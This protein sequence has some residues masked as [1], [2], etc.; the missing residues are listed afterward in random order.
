M[1]GPVASQNAATHASGITSSFCV[2]SS[3]SSAWP[4]CPKLS[5]AAA[6]GGGR[7]TSLA[8]SKLKNQ[9]EVW[10]MGTRCRDRVRNTDLRQNMGSPVHICCMNTDVKD[11]QK[12]ICFC[13]HPAF[14]D[15]DKSAMLIRILM[16]STGIFQRDGL[17]Q[18]VN[19][20][21]TT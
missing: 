8:V 15:L 6:L 21:V 19:C 13:T 5:S 14:I 17:P 10:T 7:E 2:T 11:L 12:T 20:G 16:C 4:S 3:F 9:C 18:Q 1:D